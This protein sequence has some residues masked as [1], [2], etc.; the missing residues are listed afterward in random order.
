MEG[1]KMSR[2]YW[3][4]T[5]FHGHL[6]VLECFLWTI[7]VHNPLMAIFLPLQLSYFHIYYLFD[8]FWGTKF[9]LGGREF[10]VDIKPWHLC[11][12]ACVFACL[13]RTSVNRSF[14][15]RNKSFD[16]NGPVFA[17]LEKYTLFE[18]FISKMNAL[19]ET[20]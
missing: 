7:F 17:L 19:V 3:N 16:K 18:V 8:I 15:F 1:W 11:K 5:C 13:H 9:P 14:C 12:Q 6:W 2:I 20:P 4:N 10:G